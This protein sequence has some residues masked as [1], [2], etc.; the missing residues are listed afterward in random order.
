MFQVQQLP[1]F[2]HT[3]HHRFIIPIS[4]LRPQHLSQKAAM[5][6]DIKKD[7]AEEK[8]PAAPAQPTQ[9]P[10][11]THPALRTMEIRHV[12]CATNWIGAIFFLM[13]SFCNRD[14]KLPSRLALERTLREKKRRFDSITKFLFRLHIYNIV[15]T[16]PECTK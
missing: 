1:L 12:T 11:G 2:S 13:V 5:S 14:N 16:R 4:L 10:R 3:P 15:Q 9:P 7:G 8:H 6:Q